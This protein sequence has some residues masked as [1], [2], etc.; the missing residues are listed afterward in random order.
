M[1]RVF[2]LLLFIPL[3]SCASPQKK[4]VLLD[5]LTTSGAPVCFEP[6]EEIPTFFD[7]YYTTRDLSTEEGKIDYLLERISGSGLVF[8]R[9]DVEFGSYAAAQFLRWKVDRLRVK[10]DIHINTAEE[11]VSGIASGSRASGKPYVVI[12]PDAGGSHNLQ[13]VLQNELDVLQSCLEDQ[14]AIEKAQESLQEPLTK[15]QLKSL[16][17]GAPSE[18]PEEG[19]ARQP[20]P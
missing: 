16:D 2:V 10:Y 12:I 4:T 14:A 5:G 3:L 18:P 17:E 1:K 13:F 9:N 8:I 11:F 20:A 19:L 15:E 7:Q 6:T